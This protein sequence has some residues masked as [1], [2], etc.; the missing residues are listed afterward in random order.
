MRLAPKGAALGAYFIPPSEDFTRPGTAWWSLGDKEQVPLWDQVT[1]AYHEG[2]PG[3]HLQCG[4]QVCLAD[5]LQPR[6]PPPV[7]LPGYGE[8]WALYTERL[9]HELGYFER[10][11]YVLGMLA[12]NALRAVRVVIDIGSTSSCRSPATCRSIPASRGLRLAVEAL[13]RYAFLDPRRGRLRG[14][15]LPGLAGPGHLLQ[16]RRAG[17]PRPPRGGQAK[18][19]DAFDLKAFH[20][21][22]LGSGPVGLDH[23]REI[24]LN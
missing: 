5:R 6:A 3:H 7:W 19:G 1:T 16:G 10:P 17:H 24:V 11:E 18:E 22:V 2:F 9:M 21:R 8:G 4:L 15:P 13:E 14:H 12:A 23:L 20:E